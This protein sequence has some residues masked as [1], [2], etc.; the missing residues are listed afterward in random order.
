MITFL[1]MSVLFLHEIKSKEEN[2]QKK[3]EAF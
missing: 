1:C 3:S 2:T